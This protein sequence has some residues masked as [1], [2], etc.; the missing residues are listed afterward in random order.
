MQRLLVPIDFSTNSKK[1][2]RYALDI[3]SQSGGSV[4]LYHLFRPLKATEV[5]PPFNTHD[6]NLQLEANNLKKL[7]R[8]KK[9]VLADIPVKNVTV[10]TLVGRFPVVKNILRCAKQNQIDLIV[11]GTKGATGL[12]KITVGSNAAKVVKK[13]S[14]PVLLVPEKFEWKIPEKILFTTTICKSDSLA[15]PLLSNFAKYYKTQIMVVNLRDPHQ[16]YGYKDKEEFEMYAY[17]VQRSFDNANIQFSQLDTFSISETMKNLFDE[18]P[19]DILIMVRTKKNFFEKIFSKS[20]T[21]SMAFI[22][23]RPLLVIPEE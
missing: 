4:I 22:A 11:M 7:Q 2:F 17:S 15:F 13:A 23:E 5:G 19:Y 6:Y 8:L 10:S 20:F 18:I 9:K 3:A 1:A 21:K 12:K 16:L 14:V